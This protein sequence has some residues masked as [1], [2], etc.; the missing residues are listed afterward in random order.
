MVGLAVRSRHQGY[1]QDLLKEVPAPQRE[2]I[3]NVLSMPDVRQHL[4]LLSRDQ[5]RSTDVGGIFRWMLREFRNQNHVAVSSKGGQIR[6]LSSLL[7][8]GK[9]P[10]SFRP[11]HWCVHESSATDLVLGDG[12]VF[13]T[14]NE[15]L[16][17][18]L[19]CFGQSWNAFYLPISPSKLLVGARSL[20]S[21]IPSA[22][23]VN[24][25]SAELSFSHIYA[26]AAGDAEL[27]LAQRIGTA[28]PLLSKEEL[29]KIVSEGLGPR[30]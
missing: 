11:D 25:A 12:C 9:A 26:R 10:E 17:G 22:S 18:S 21:P 7:E 23:E 3:Q 15:G 1:L 19:F 20:P 2:V 5:A 6:S 16:V 29:A 28:D 4:L 14:S 8:K 24:R 13:A 27:S 30:L